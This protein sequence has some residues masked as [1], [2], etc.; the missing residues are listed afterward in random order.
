[1]RM[2]INSPVFVW[3]HHNAGKYIIGEI[4]RFIN[5]EGKKQDI[6]YYNRQGQEFKA[7]IPEELKQHGYPLFGLETF[8]DTSR[9]LIICEGQK[10][11]SAFAGLGFQCVTSILGA[12]N[13]HRSNWKSIDDAN[14]IY[15]CPD[16]D[17]SGDNYAQTI[18]KLISVPASSQQIKIVRLPNLPEKG[19][20]CDWLKQQP[21]LHDWN[22]F[23]SLANHRSRDILFQ[24]LQKTIEEN[25]HEIPAHWKAPALPI[26]PEW[27]DPEPIQNILLPV[28]ALRPC[29]IPEAYHDWIID[30]AERMQCPPDFIATAAIVVTASI[31]GAGCGI[32]PKQKDDWLVVPNLWGG[33]VGRPGM[34]KTPAVAEVMQ[35]LSILETEAKINFDENQN[36]YN[37]ELEL[38][39]AGKEA[40]KSEMLAAQKKVFKNKF[41]EM[42]LDPISLKNKFINHKE[43]EKPIWKRY[44]TNDATIE[45]LSELLSD[46]PRGLL[47]YRDELIGLL[48]T[49]DKEGRES[50]RAFFLEAWNG[51]GSLTTDRIGRGTVHTENLCISVFGNTQPSKLLHYLNNAMRGCDNDGLMQRFQLFI[52][53][54]EPSRWQL[55]DRQPDREAKD[56]VFKIIRKLT[57][58]DFTQHGAIKDTRDRFPYFRF[59]E[60]SQSFFYNWLTNLECEKLQAD[61]QP[62]VLEH[63]SK[64]RSLMPS[65]AL[66]FHLIEIADGAPS[67]H[68]SISATARAIGW[69]DYLES[70]ARRIYGMAAN[71]A[72]QAAIKLSKKIQDGELHQCFSVRDVY[73]K[74]WGLLED[75]DTIQKACHELLEADW[76]RQTSTAREMGRPKHPTYLINPKIK[77]KTP[78]PS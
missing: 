75:K 17:V 39:K 78:D 60:E 3:Q 44:K 65:L 66:I 5:K 29:I 19:D 11:Q 36:E 76:L 68:I 38:Y 10:A 52:Y 31:I 34:L 71:I 43:P 48:A 25:L 18:Y 9:I 63:L 30:I 61:D 55:I 2:N 21:E 59:D 74:H 58:M 62:I 32:K 7:G 54:D 24:R 67:Q 51:Y 28:E 40:L 12:S 1:M 45:K 8:K 26:K 70:H 72:N 4:K 46:N 41:D 20:V 49:W 33:V 73:R 42:I 22:E 6:P 35:L 16:N 57:E 77:M 69:C 53:P 64:Y 14:L 37:A 13:A 15:F 23:N 56:R 47:L 50:D 27:P